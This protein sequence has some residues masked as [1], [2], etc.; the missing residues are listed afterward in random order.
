MSRRRV[1]RNEIDVAALH[2]MSSPPAGGAS[3]QAPT[4]WLGSIEP[5]TP[6]DI[7]LTKMRRHVIVDAVHTAFGPDARIYLFGSRTDDRKFGGD[8]DL[9][10]EVGRSDEDWLRSMLRAGGRIQRRIGERKIDLVVTD[11][12]PERE[13]QLIIRNARRQGVPL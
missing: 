8:I 11:G 12:S 5:A 3:I 10:I 13:G 6:N 9:L 2:Y 4:S 7:Q 1:E